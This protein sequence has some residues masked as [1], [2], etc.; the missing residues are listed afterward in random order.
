MAI[1]TISPFLFYEGRR[2]IIFPSSLF[3][4]STSSSPSPAFPGR[5]FAL[6]WLSSPL[7]RKQAH[8]AGISSP[9]QPWAEDMLEDRQEDKLED[10][11]GRLG[12]KGNSHSIQLP[13]PNRVLFQILDLCLLHTNPV[14]E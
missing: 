12:H 13:A 14:Q 4:F 11:V 3:G 8:P 1:F 6:G 10:I 9:P 5:P 7:P 2:K